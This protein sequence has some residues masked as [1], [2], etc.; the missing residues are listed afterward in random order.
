MAGTRTADEI[1]RL[2]EAADGAATG[3]PRDELYEAVRRDE[4]LR[5][6]T[7]AERLPQGDWT[8]DEL[9]DELHGEAGGER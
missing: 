3:E 8:L 9:V 7:Y 1:G 4:T 5:V 2:V 6:R